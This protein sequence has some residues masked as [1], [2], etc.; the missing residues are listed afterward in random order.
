MRGRLA[1]QRFKDARKLPQGCAM[2]YGTPVPA[3]FTKLSCVVSCNSLL[4]TPCSSTPSPR[5]TAASR[6]LVA[7]VAGSL[8]AECACSSCGVWAHRRRP[9]VVWTQ[10]SRALLWTASPTPLPRPSNFAWTTGYADSLLRPV[11]GPAKLNAPARRSRRATHR[12]REAA[13]FQAL[14]AFSRLARHP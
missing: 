10:R 5:L 8:P 13:V 7:P 1:I 9:S 14:R 6:P 4:V 3:L 2:S 11:S 12:L